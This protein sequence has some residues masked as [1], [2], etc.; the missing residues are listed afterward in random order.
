MKRRFFISL[1]AGGL[2][3]SV[4]KINSVDRLSD[5]FSKNDQQKMPT[6]FVGHGS[7]MNA[8]SEN[9]FTQTLG[10]IGEKYPRPNAVL[11]ISAHWM[12]RGTWIT[13]IERPKTIHD[14][15]GFPKELFEV[16][17]PASGSPKLAE[18]IHKDLPSIH[19]DNEWGLDH[20]TW[21]I[22]RKMYP[23]ADIP[24]VQ[25]S[26][27]MTQGPGYHIKL[28][29]ELSKLRESGVL[30][31]GSGNIVHN[32]RRLKWEDNATPYDWAI[33]FNE[34]TKNKIIKRDLLSL[35]KDILNSEAGKLSIPTM[36]HYYP[37][38]YVLGASSKTDEIHFEYEEIQ[39]GSIS[40][41]TVRFGSI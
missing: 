17:Y 1:G 12:T 41:L 36:D 23:L 2:I 5:L 39:N 30:I 20:G 6:L 25:L 34:W 14:F 11:C 26:L 3:M 37:F 13:Q 33:E 27:D 32:L 31:L 29:E 15:G 21:A 22:L 7:P 10:N 38:L 35:Q 24:V 9:P 28:G 16:Q 4:V 18:Q 19:L 40:M 8:I